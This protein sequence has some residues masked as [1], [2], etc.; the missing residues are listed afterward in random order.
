MPKRLN[1]EQRKRFLEGRHVA[2]LATI[3]SQGEPVL[4]PIW[5]VY[6]GRRI[7][8]RTSKDSVKARN[9]ERDPRVTV[10]VQDEAA[11][12]RSVTIHGQ[13]VLEGEHQELGARIA[14]RYLGRVGG[15]AYQR[16]AADQV[17]QAEEV[18]I[19]VTPDKV[20]TQD[21]SA[22]TPLVGKVWLRLKKVLP[23]GL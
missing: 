14:R 8:M 17:Q 10:C 21:F 16:V 19:A 13:A 9:I 6:E 1:G 22:E 23:A 15:M 12:Y 7:L 11:P 4:T 18:T 20:L 2:V 5:Y 3:G